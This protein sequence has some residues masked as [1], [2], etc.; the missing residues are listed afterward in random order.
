MSD[1]DEA[2]EKT[3]EGDDKELEV[4][5]QK[6]YEERGMDFRDYKRASIKR[7][8]QK[9][10]EANNLTSYGEYMNLLD[11]QP[12]EYA[13]LFDTLLINVTEFFRDPEAFEVLEK[14]IIP[15]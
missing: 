8:I 6:I 2:K 14:D 10:L 15:K 5:L 9:R 13:K 12:E 7:R 3:A 1:K 11:R 4:L